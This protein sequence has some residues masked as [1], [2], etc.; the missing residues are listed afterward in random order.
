MKKRRRRGEEIPSLEGDSKFTL[1][2]YY[3]FTKLLKILISN[4]YHYHLVDIS[5]KK[6]DRMR[7]EMTELHKDFGTFA[8]SVIV[9]EKE[10]DKL[11]SKFKSNMSGKDFIKIL[12]QVRALQKMDLKAEVD[13]V[14]KIEKETIERTLDDM[15]SC[16]SVVGR[17]SKTPEI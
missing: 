12:S 17:L 3:H 10:L 15:T 16:Y 14:R 4:L 8:N 7:M 1:N 11:E 6:E 13:H 5:L 9:A 2:R